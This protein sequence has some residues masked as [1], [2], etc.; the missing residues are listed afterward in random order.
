MKFN[1]NNSNEIFQSKKIII[2]G[3][4]F[5]DINMWASIFS[6]L[7]VSVNRYLLIKLNI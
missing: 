1:I 3:A 6:T 5:I 7:T 2:N 4:V